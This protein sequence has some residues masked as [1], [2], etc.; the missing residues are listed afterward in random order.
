M[1]SGAEFAVGPFVDTDRL[2]PESGKPRSCIGID[3]LKKSCL[4]AEAWPRPVLCVT[5]DS[6]TNL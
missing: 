3:S 1:F 2:G 4:A 5:A 6:N